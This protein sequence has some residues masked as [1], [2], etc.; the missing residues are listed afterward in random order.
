MGATEMLA[1]PVF[2]AGEKVR[3]RRTDDVAQ[4]VIG[5]VRRMQQHHASVAVVGRTEVECDTLYAALKA[6]DLEPQRITADQQ[7]YLGG[8]SV[9]PS[10]LTKGLE[11]DGVIVPDA[12]AHHYGLNHRDARL[13]YVVCT[14]AL[15]E[16][17]LLYTGEI[18]PLLDS[19]P[20][21]LYAG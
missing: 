10:Y 20:P 12:G 21:E 1:Q 5:E 14:R 17:S 9:I 15:H 3:L 19:V 16:L 6:A 13:L 18:S 8:L 4:A 11:F 2:R 7:R